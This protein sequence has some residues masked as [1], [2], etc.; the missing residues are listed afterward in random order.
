MKNT[1]TFLKTTAILVSSTLLMSSCATMFSGKTTPVVLINAPKDLK[2]SENGSELSVQRVQ[3]HVKGNLDE[4]TT[5]YYAPGVELDKKVKRHTLTLSSGGKTQTV[6]IKLRAGGKWIILDA[7]V[8]GVFA[9]TTDAI[10]KKWRVAGNKYVD[11][12][13]VLDGTKQKS[14]LKLKRIMKRQA[15]G[16]G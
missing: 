13:A 2:V 9:W 12:P 15:K 5:T 7:C 14:Q 11:V 16:K 10:T 8:G 6:D 1:S 4:S 3:A